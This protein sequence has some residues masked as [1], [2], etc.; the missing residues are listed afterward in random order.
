MYSSG[1]FQSMTPERFFDSRDP[2]WANTAIAS[3]Y[4][5]GIGIGGKSTVPSTASAVVA[6]VTAVPA[7]SGFVSVFPA[8]SDLTLATQSSSLNMVVGKPVANAVWSELSSGAAS[9][10]LAGG[11]RGLAAGEIGVHVSTAAWIIVD[12]AGWFTAA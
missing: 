9:P 11:S 5:W 12:V 1:R 7:N 10:S 2:V 4:P 8:D 3:P 6:N